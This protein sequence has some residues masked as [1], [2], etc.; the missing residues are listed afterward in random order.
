[1]AFA[2]VHHVKPCAAH[3]LQHPAN[4]LDWGAGQRQVVIMMAVIG[5]LA[6][7]FQTV[8]PLFAMRDLDGTTSPSRS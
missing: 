1:M 7:N 8:L 5:T 3:A 4:R 2:R 6:F